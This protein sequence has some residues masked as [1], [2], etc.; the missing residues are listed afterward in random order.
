M[1]HKLDQ[2]QTRTNQPA[3]SFWSNLWSLAGSVFLWTVFDLAS[4]SEIIDGATFKKSLAVVNL[5]L[6]LYLPSG[7]FPDFYCLG[8]L[9]KTVSLSLWFLIESIAGPVLVLRWRLIYRNALLWRLQTDGV[10]CSMTVSLHSSQ[11]NDHG[12][13]PGTW[14]AFWSKQNKSPTNLFA[15]FI[16]SAR[17]GT[18]VSPHLRSSRRISFLLSHACFEHFIISYRYLCFLK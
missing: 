13:L 16:S 8:R 4:V 10:V 18:F 1:I 11:E 2:H 12:S 15:A 7:C 17:H 3:H 14:L 5:L 6:F 9:A